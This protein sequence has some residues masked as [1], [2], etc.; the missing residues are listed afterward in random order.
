V[1]VDSKCVL[2]AMKRPNKMFHV[3]FLVSYF[4][5]TFNNENGWGL[6]WE[7]IVFFHDGKFAFLA[8][9][10]IVFYLDGQD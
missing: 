8:I 1:S 5:L 10:I 3:L 2:I 6:V 4:I 9:D 7:W